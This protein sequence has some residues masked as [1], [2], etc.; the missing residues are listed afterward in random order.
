MIK[1]KLVIL[2]LVFATSAS[3]VFCKKFVRVIEPVH[4]IDERQ[5]KKRLINKIK[6]FC[7][8]EIQALSM[9]REEEEKKRKHLNEW[10]LAE[11]KA[12]ELSM[13]LR[14]GGIDS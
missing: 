1:N 8:E 6:K 4:V 5:E 10:L 2:L 14:F 12:F 3:T 9:T 13:H 7:R 11:L